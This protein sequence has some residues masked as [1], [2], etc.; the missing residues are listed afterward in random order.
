L[1]YK[2]LNVNIEQWGQKVKKEVPGFQIILY[3]NGSREK[4]YSQGGY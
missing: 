3:E 2:I 4:I 1:I